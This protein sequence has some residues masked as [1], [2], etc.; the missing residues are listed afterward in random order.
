MKSEMRKI[1]IIIT[2]LLGT[3][4][5]VFAQSDDTLTLT[6][7]QAV[8]IAIKH[9]PSLEAGNSGAPDQS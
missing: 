1:G 4:S 3:A 8:A 5:G 2:I 6:L 7:S 9:S